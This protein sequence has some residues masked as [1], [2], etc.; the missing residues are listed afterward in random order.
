[1]AKDDEVI[2]TS[3]EMEA[4]EYQKWEFVLQELKPGIEADES[5]F[6]PLEAESII[7]EAKERRRNKGV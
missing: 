4:S 1:M 5:M 7:A 3:G 2:S 6:V